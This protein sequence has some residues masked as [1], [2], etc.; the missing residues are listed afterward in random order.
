MIHKFIGFFFLSRFFGY[1]AGEFFCLDRWYCYRYR[2]HFL[3]CPIALAARREERLRALAEEL[4]EHRG[5]VLVVACDVSRD[6]DLLRAVAEARER[7]ARV[8]HVIANAGF[9][10]AGRLERLTLED[11]RR[12][13]ETNVFG[14]LRTVYATLDDLAA[15]RGCLAIIGSVS[16]YVALPGTS[17]YFNAG[18]CVIP[19]QLTG[20]EIEN[21]RISMVKWTSAP[22]KPGDNGHGI[23]RE[24]IAPPRHLAHLH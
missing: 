22:H 1:G 18:S 12:Q 10:V 24:L 14:V 5:G 20:L 11:Y 13:L 7:F 3:L 8:D 16:G 19:G 15:T 4:E 6:G 21:G 9:G 2:G 23:R 17:P